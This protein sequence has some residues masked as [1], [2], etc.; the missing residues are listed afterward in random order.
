M[1]R[2]SA[3]QAALATLA[4]PLVSRVSAQ[5]DWPST[6]TDLNVALSGIHPA[7]LL[8][9]LYET[10]PQAALSENDPKLITVPW[11]A[12]LDNVLKHATGMVLYADASGPTV[13]PDAAG[14]T[15]GAIAIC[16]SA[17][18]AYDLLKLATTGPL[19][20]F[21]VEH[22]VAGGTQATRLRN[23]DVVIEITRINYAILG[24]LN[25]GTTLEAL[26]GHLEAVLS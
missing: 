17:D 20:G 25:Q 5:S 10:E 2:R 11:N 15:A 26:M 21:E 24:T 6:A 19:D 16:D 22:F 9:R 13:S 3:I 23:N 18:I 14:T 4:V 7:E 12:P 1:N 8:T